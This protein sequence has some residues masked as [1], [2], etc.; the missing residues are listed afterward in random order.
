MREDLQPRKLDHSLQDPGYG[1]IDMT[2]PSMDYMDTTDTF[3]DKRAFGIPFKID[4]EKAQ[5][6]ACQHHGT[7]V[8]V[9]S[10]ERLLVP[11]WMA[12]TCAG[13]TFKAEVLRQHPQF[14]RP[15][16]NWEDVPTMH[17]TYPFEEHHV[18][19]QIAATYDVAPDVL[20]NIVSG[21]HIP[22]ML[23]SRYELLEECEEMPNAPK[24]LPFQV[25]T[26]SATKVLENR[27]NRA[28]LDRYAKKELKKFYPNGWVSVNIRFIGI[29][30]E[31]IKIKPVFLPL[32][33]LHCATVSHTDFELPTYVCGATG[34]TFGPIIH[35]NL[36][37][38]IMIGAV[39][40]M[41][42][43]ATMAPVVGPALGAVGAGLASYGSVY[44]RHFRAV[45][46][47]K[48]DTESADENAQRLK[49]NNAAVDSNGYR[50]K[51]EDEERYE[52]EHREELREKARKRMRFEQRV[53]EEMAQD[54]AQAAQAKSEE[55]QRKAKPRRSRRPGSQD[56]DPLGYYLVLGLKG[57]EASATKSDIAKAF[58]K[59]AQTHH[60]DMVSIDKQDEA[61][62]RMQKI[63]E[64]Y[65]VLRDAKLRKE[66]DTGGIFSSTPQK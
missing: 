28:L 61:K 38:K 56:L 11:F 55:H 26:K 12:H 36:R 22:S 50:W 7:T 51:V 53:K 64:A 1:Y 10:V 35:T 16:Y 66:Y 2:A 33:K 27:I 52:Y 18:F 17:F 29:I 23:I 62:A 54:D 44:F 25:S 32:Y 19:N 58:R 41:G 14:F 15:T 46:K 57:K 5:D 20:H 6:L 65:N 8:E 42:G 43:L 9:R 34:K 47:A 31:L 45:T 37:R 63:V 49:T 30:F 21:D 13:G 39:G 60:P 48:F 59:E 3:I 4:D 40:A 24:L